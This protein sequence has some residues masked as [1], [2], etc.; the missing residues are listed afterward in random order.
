MRD[1]Y[2]GAYD[3]LKL[4]GDLTASSFGKT[5]RSPR[6]DHHNGLLKLNRSLQYFLVLLSAV[7]PTNVPRITYY[8]ESAMLF[9]PD[10]V[11]LRLKFDFGLKFS[12]QLHF[13]ISLFRLW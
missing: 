4:P 6:D 1:I 7:K 2:G 5:V 9:I 12:K 11:L 10:R 8:I 3:A 13:D